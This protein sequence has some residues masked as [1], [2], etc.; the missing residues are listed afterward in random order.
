VYDVVYLDRGHQSTVIASGVNGDIAAD[1]ARHEAKA[2][3]AARMFSQG[4]E[5]PNQGHLVLIV[6]AAS[7]TAGGT[8]PS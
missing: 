7:G 4:S 6:A 3:Q 2:R 5:P 1:V 8:G